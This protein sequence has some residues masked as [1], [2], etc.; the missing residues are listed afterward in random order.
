MFLHTFTFFWQV[1]WLSKEIL[2]GKRF[3]S[4]SH[5]ERKVKK[6]VLRISNKLNRKQKSY[7]FKDTQTNTFTGWQTDKW[8]FLTS[9]YKDIG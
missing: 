9:D 4:I 5:L 7:L 2:D 1:V 6:M 3:K 8:S